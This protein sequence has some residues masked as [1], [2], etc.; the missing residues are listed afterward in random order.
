MTLE[1][2]REIDILR[3]EVYDLYQLRHEIIE[4]NAYLDWVQWHTKHTHYSTPSF[5][6]RTAKYDSFDYPCENIEEW[7]G[8]FFFTHRDIAE[9]MSKS[10][11]RQGYID[12]VS[13]YQQHPFISFIEPSEYN[14][15][16]PLVSCEAVLPSEEGPRLILA[17]PYN[18]IMTEPLRE[19]TYEDAV[20]FIDQ[21]LI[22]EIGFRYNSD[23]HPVKNIVCTG[24]HKYEPIKESHRPY[25]E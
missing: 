25:S 3:K 13:Y 7:E 18:T 2:Q 17:D 6:N 12:D 4:H 8:T 22:V 14:Y 23:S 20:K 11:L 15:I 1:E 5:S 9:T 10:Y 19:I 24:Y 16:K 21:I